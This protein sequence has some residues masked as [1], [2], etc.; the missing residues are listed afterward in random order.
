LLRS[1]DLPSLPAETLLDLFCFHEN[2]GEFRRAEADLDALAASGAGGVDL[3][4]ERAAFYTRL[5]ERDPRDLARLD[6]DRAELEAKLRN[7]SL[8]GSSTT[9][10][11]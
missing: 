10:V 3:R 8:R 5:L 7:L 2:A 1:L 9:V 6:I 11:E 4:T